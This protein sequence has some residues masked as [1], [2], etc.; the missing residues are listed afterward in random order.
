MATRLRHIALSVRDLAR[1]QKFFED[2]FGMKKVGNG[3]HGVYMSDG[4]INVALLD[5]KGQPDSDAVPEPFYG[6]LHFGMWVDDT[7]ETLE[8]VK[9]AGGAYLSGNASDNPNTFFEVKCTD[10]DGTVFDLTHN[11]WRGAVKEVAPVEEET[12]PA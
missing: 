7:D 10:P 1:S 8:K 3:A 6:V 12:E 2:A 5:R 11:G 4:T 9:Q